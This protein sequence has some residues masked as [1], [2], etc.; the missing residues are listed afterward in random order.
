MFEAASRREIINVKYVRNCNHIKRVSS[1]YLYAIVKV[2]KITLSSLVKGTATYHSVVKILVSFADSLSLKY[3]V[4]CLD[5]ST[6]D[7]NAKDLSLCDRISP[8]LP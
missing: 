1:V 5:T 7:P 6:N 3:M 2:S 4:H 8:A